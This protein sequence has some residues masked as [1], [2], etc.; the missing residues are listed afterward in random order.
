[1]TAD[2]ATPTVLRV[3]GRSDYGPIAPPVLGL[4]LVDHSGL[5][6]RTARTP[7]ALPTTHR[8]ARERGGWCQKYGISRLRI[9]YLR[10]LASARKASEATGF[11]ASLLT[12]L[13]GSPYVVIPQEESEN[14]RS[15][16]QWLTA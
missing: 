12:S 14:D 13:W 2:T 10:S 1:M 16:A 11:S 8:V 3:V 5:R 6:S 9:R 4:R 15:E 7:K